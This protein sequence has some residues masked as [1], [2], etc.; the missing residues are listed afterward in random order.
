MEDFFEGPKLLSILLNFL[1]L[2]ATSLFP[3]ASADRRKRD[4]SPAA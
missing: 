3:Q 4:L 1:K 2:L